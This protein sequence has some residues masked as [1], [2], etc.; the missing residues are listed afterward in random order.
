MIELTSASREELIEA[1]RGLVARVAELEAENL[2]LRRGG[3]TPAELWIRPSRPAKEKQKRKHRAQGFVRRREPADEVREHAMERCPDCGR[4]LTGGTPHRRR[5]VIEL[6]LES[7]VVER[8]AGSLPHVVLSRY[9]SL[10]DKRW[11]PKLEDEEIGAVGKRRF[12][13]SV[14][15]LVTLLHIAGRLPIRKRGEETRPYRKRGEETRPYRMIRQLLRETCDLH[16]SNGAVGD[17]LEGVAAKAEPRVKAILEQVRAS[18]AVCGD[19]TGW[20]EDGVNQV[21]HMGYV[22]TFSTPTLRYFV[23]DAS[24]ASRVPEEVLGEDFAGTVTCDFY[25][26]YNKLGVL[27][28][29]W[30]HLLQE[31]EELA[32]RNADR[33]DVKSWEQALKALYQEAT[34]FTEACRESPPDSRLRRQARRRLEQKAKQLARPYAKDPQALQRVLAQ[35]ILKH[36]PELFVFVTNPAVPAT[37]NLAERSL[38]PLV[39]ARKISG[40]TR[41][42]KGS[43]TMM[44]LMSLLG[45]WLLQGKPLHATCQKML[46][47]PARAP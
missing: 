35:R 6:V 9:C 24:R 4:K 29:C 7:R 10:C 45:T 1:I 14:Q 27:Q 15:S 18:E 5:Q 25:A 12:G 40:G 37:N 43:D 36:L 41:S 11:L 3:G 17:L 21:Q 42:S 8:E 19:E 26:A 47:S 39:I 30:F 38:R 31:A 44:K 46:L 2:R 33:P 28:R 13:A 23:R 32:E 16:L 20:R 34:A 22:W